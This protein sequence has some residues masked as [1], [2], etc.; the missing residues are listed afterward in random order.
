MALPTF[1]VHAARRGLRGA[2]A[3][4]SLREPAAWLA[5]HSQFTPLDAASQR[6][7][8]PADC[9]QQTKKNTRSV[10]A[11]ETGAHRFKVSLKP[12]Q[13]LAESRGRASGRPSQRAKLPSV[14]FREEKGLGKAPLSKR[15]SLS[16]S[17]SHPRSGYFFEDIQTDIHKS[18][19][20]IYMQN[21]HSF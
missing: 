18:D 15:G 10:P 4:I 17:K 7:L 1:A 2:P 14:Q 8:L 6:L 20:H 21:R 9:A 19:M 11:N 3:G 12:F 13:R 5:Q 16:H